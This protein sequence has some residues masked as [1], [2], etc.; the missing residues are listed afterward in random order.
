M[1][2]KRN[3]VFNRNAAAIRRQKK[4][5]KRAEYEVNQNK[6]KTQRNM[7]TR[8]LTNEKETLSTFDTGNNKK[9]TEEAAKTVEE[10]SLNE[11]QPKKTGGSN[12]PVQRDASQ[13][14]R[15]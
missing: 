15:I 13:P 5:K 9:K 3:P 6:M 14:I 7:L 8:R 10:L 12:V 11:W 4:T 2:H 1:C